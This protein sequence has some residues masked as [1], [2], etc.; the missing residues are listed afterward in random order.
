[1]RMHKFCFP[2]IISI[3]R[4]LEIVFFILLILKV[5]YLQKLVALF[6]YS[7]EKIVCFTIDCKGLD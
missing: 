6:S 3:G 7:A 1:M 2:V 5:A 4:Q